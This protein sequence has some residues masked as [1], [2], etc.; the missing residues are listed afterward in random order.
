MRMPA[1]IAAVFLSL[2]SALG[3]GP[4]TLESLDKSGPPTS[5]EYITDVAIVRIENLP[6][7]ARVQ[8]EKQVDEMDAGEFRS[9]HSTIESSP[10]MV[11]ALA[12]VGL[13]PSQVVA[14]VLDSEGA[15]TLVIQPTA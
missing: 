6:P 5:Y 3:Q 12:Q 8:I 13:D 11:T 14:A 9:L 2:G 15:L 4:G 10:E 1:A 7:Q